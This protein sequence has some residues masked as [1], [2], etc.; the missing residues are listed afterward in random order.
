MVSGEACDRAA[1][2]PQAG[3]SLDHLV[4]VD[5]GHR[6]LSLGQEA[7]VLAGVAGS[8]HHVHLV[9][10]D[11]ARSGFQES[12]NL[13]HEGGLAGALPINREA[14]LLSQ[15]TAVAVIGI[16]SAAGTIAFGAWYYDLSLSLSPLVL[17]VV[18]LAI[19]SLAGVGV[20]IAM[21]SPF[22]QLT[23]A[24][25]Q[26]VIFYVLLFAPVLMP[27]AQLP[28]LLRRTADF[29]PPTYVA[30]AVRATVT[31]LP[32]T[33][34]VKSVLVMAIFGVAST[35]VSSITVRHRGCC[36][37]ASCERDWRT[38]GVGPP[39]RLLPLHLAPP[40]APPKPT[41]PARRCPGRGPYR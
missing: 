5:A 21:L 38:R 6:N 32:G 35:A 15:L 26:L 9:D 29:M 33:N 20:M 13:A 34:L 17:L 3:D 16:P 37:G 1:H 27:A 40:T 23:N 8:S 25:T 22:E 28:W 36:Q 24:I 4:D 31:S 7:N 19:L 39:I 11:G 12:K 41:L 14:Y 2:P 30:D 18:P 10:S